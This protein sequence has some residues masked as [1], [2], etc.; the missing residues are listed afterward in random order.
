MEYQI[1]LLSYSLLDRAMQFPEE[2]DEKVAE[3]A[4][5]IFIR[6]PGLRHEHDEAQKLRSALQRLGEVPDTDRDGKA[7]IGREAW[8]VFESLDMT[9]DHN[10]PYEHYSDLK[11]AFVLFEEENRV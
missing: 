10:R 9:F 6:V 1:K 3:Y 5:E 8:D 11:P 4:L 2:V 7:R